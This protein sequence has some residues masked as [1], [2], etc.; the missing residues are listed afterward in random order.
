MAA[1]FRRLTRG[2]IK[3]TRNRVSSLDNL[4]DERK[5]ATAAI[6][7]F[8]SDDHLHFTGENNSDAFPRRRAWTERTDMCNEDKKLTEDW[9]RDWQVGLKSH[10]EVLIKLRIYR[11]ISSGTEG[12]KGSTF[13]LSA[14]LFLEIF[15]GEY[16]S[17]SGNFSEANSRGIPKFSINSYNFL[18]AIFGPFQLILLPEFKFAF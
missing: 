1:K 3:G 2:Y 17:I 10:L 14:D 5:P 9:M 16:N 12:R 4:L 6:N 13:N 11:L 7:R 18:Q 8:P 15:S